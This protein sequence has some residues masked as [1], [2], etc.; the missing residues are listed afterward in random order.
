MQIVCEK[1]EIIDPEKRIRRAGYGKLKN[2]RGEVSYVKRLAKDL[3][4][5]FHIYILERG[6]KIIFNLHLDQR[7]TVYQGVTA[8]AGEYDGAVVERE[9]KRIKQLFSTIS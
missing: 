3:Y 7:K 5:R 8:H 9:V 6:E 2:R 1:K 4:P